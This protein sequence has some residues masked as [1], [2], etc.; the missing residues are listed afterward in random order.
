MGFMGITSIG[1]SDN[2][3]DF[4]SEVIGSIEETIRKEMT[5]ETN[6]YNTP[7]YINVGLLLISLI[8][9]ENEFHFTYQDEWG[10][11]WEYLEKT[12][13]KNKTSWKKTDMWEDYERLMDFV[14]EMNNICKNN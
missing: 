1:D 11:I 8:S 5:E 10:D 3:S 7:G 6:E 13:K 14:I 12:Y 2:A 9:D 4:A